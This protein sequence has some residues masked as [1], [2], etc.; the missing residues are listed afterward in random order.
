MSTRFERN[1]DFG[2]ISSESAF[3][4]ENTSF[5][6]VP[7]FIE[8][9]FVEAPRLDHVRV[10]TVAGLRS[11]GLGAGPNVTARY[12]ALKRL[13]ILGHDH[14][15]EHAF[16][17]GEIQSLRGD[18]DRKWPSFKKRL[19]KSVGIHQKIWPGAARYWVGI[20]YEIFSD[21]GRSIVR[22]V[23]SW[24]LA[25]ALFTGA[26]LFHILLDI[27]GCISGT[28]GPVLS[29]IYLSVRKGLIFPGL[30]EDQKLD[31]AY[32][33]LYGTTIL[34]ESGIRIPVIPESV[35][36]LGIVQA[37]ISAVLIF[38]F[39]LAVR[40]HFR[41]KNGKPTASRAAPWARR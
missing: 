33:C 26:C 5:E 16:F 17:A 9:H 24:L 20:F 1:A 4:L 30:K 39:L 13:A 10:P 27:P 12:R 8:A 38:L 31:Q 25:T 14:E 19:V 7:D 28:V 6:N 2:A 3:S 22:P 37:L 15:R 11:A 41:I 29:A 32:A 40:N 23:A 18:P 35:A 21:F 36:Y 34:T